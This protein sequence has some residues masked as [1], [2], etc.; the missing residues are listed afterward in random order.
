MIKTREKEHF[1]TQIKFQTY[2]SLFSLSN[3]S[4]R[5][6]SKDSILEDW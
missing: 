5:R 4:A 2:F 3:L 6:K 1:A